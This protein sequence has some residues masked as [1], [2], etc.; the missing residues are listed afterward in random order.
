MPFAT[1]RTVSLIGAVGHVIDVQA[2]VSPG[3]VATVLVGRPDAALN[4]ARDRCRMAIINSQLPWPSTRRTT[5]LLS[6]ADLPK[7]G[8]HYDLAIAVAVLGATGNV[9][10]DALDGVAF[11]GELTLDGGLRSVPG[12][13]PMVLAAARQGVHRLVVPEPQA[14]EAAM[15]PG[16]DVLGVRSLSQVVAE[17]RGEPVPEAP[18]VTEMAGSRL[19]SWRGSG[20]MEQLDLA[21]L[22]G[23]EDTRFAVEVAA[24]GGHHLLLSGPKGSGKTSIAER[25]PGL[26]PDLT[27]EEAL[28]LTA[29]HSLA[30][31]LEPGDGLRTRPPFTAPHHD[32]STASLVGGGAGAVRPGEISRAHCGVL[33]L[34]EFPLFRTDVINALRQPLESGEITV[35]RAEESVVLPARSIV[36]LAA[37]PCPCGEFHADVRH[38]KCQCREVQRRDYRRKVTGPITDR[39]DITRHLTAATPYASRDPLAV[40]EST[41]TVR[42]RVE[43]AR[44]RQAQR[45][46][47]EGWRLNGHAPGPA[48]AAQWPLDDEAG[49]LVDEHLWSGRL[50][51]RGVTRVHRLAWTVADLT[52]QDRPGAE[53]ADTALRL[54]SGTPLMANA[55]Q[56]RAG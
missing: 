37:N 31:A 34:D 5:I 46:A 8:T 17:L 9:S 6:P 51:R 29:V 25:I 32:A 3:Q 35:A 30:G 21:D 55:L 42:S 11:L 20:R 14:A 45:Y 13:L 4:E 50:T 53:E 23:M 16:V 52:G 40:R 28:E 54:R 7:R 22:V 24:A 12:V 44:E 47:G 41:A 48:L 49:R 27:R 56:R 1:S 18:A 38:N 26:L 15:V 2:D 10:R 33:L 43:A 39:I 19:L 36:V